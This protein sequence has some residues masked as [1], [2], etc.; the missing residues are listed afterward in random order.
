[1]IAPKW[2]RPRRWAGTRSW[3]SRSVS[4]FAGSSSD[5][6]AHGRPPAVVERQER[7]VLGILGDR[8][9]A[10]L[11]QAPGGRGSV[12]WAEAPSTSVGTTCF[13][14][15]AGLVPGAARNGS[16]RIA[17]DVRHPGGVGAR[18]VLQRALRQVAEHDDPARTRTRPGG[19]GIPLR[20]REALLLRRRGAAAGR[21]RRA[22]R[23]APGPARPGAGRCP[24]GPGA[25]R[26]GFA[27]A[28]IVRP[29]RIRK[30]TSAPRIDED[31]HRHDQLEHR[32]TAG[33]ST[34]R[35]ACRRHRRLPPAA[36][37]RSLCSTVP[38]RP[39]RTSSCGP[40]GSP[41]PAG[42]GRLAGVLVGI[43]AAV[44][45]DDAYGRRRT[46]QGKPGS[47]RSVSSERNTPPRTR[48]SMRPTKDWSRPRAQLDGA[49][50]G[51]AR[52]RSA[53]LSSAPW[54]R[55]R[56]P[57]AVRSLDAVDADRGVG[58]VVAD[59]HVLQPPSARTGPPFVRKSRSRRT[60]LAALFS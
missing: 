27:A 38:Y 20:P 32:E 10:D 36:A 45:V 42:A 33:V 47:S 17:G 46:D 60:P 4:R 53:R 21:T 9:V 18:P 15:A 25:P 23:G 51:D 24:C 22:A 12:V 3:I 30:T 44:A 41:C 16:L 58:P 5:S 8:D 52:R 34:A 37:A 54:P 55:R 13:R 6:T 39:R 19:G 14:P 57:P 29:W 59:L 7:G 31:R 1:M 11:A 56:P 28:K 43:Q 48:V 40:S 49:A 2:R 35:E 50:L 26:R